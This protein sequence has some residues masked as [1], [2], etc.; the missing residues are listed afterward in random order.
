MFNVEIWND[1]N[2]FHSV[3][4]PPGVCKYKRGETNEDS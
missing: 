2:I 1:W 4:Y 3:A